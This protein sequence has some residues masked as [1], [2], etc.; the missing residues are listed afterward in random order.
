MKHSKRILP[1]LAAL[2][3]VA[4]T[5]CSR[6]DSGPIRV[7]QKITISMQTNPQQ[8]VAKQP[9]TFQVKVNEEGRDLQHVDVTLFLEMKDMDHGENKVVLQEGPPGVYSGKGTFPMGGDW[10]AHLRAKTDDDTQTANLPV[11]VIE[12]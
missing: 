3:L 2:L 9:T 11:Q 5:G 6:A 7:D 12:K 1:V 4:V 10:V 8:P